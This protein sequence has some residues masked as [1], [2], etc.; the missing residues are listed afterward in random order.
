MI[1]VQLED[2][3]Y[4]FPQSPTAD[5]QKIEVEVLAFTAVA[6]FID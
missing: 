3:T 5:E 4:T 6:W 1:P 2:G